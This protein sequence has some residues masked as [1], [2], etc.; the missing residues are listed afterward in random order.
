MNAKH[1]VV[2][3]GS[4][5]ENSGSKAV[6]EINGLVLR[7]VVSGEAGEGLPYAP[8]NWPNPGDI[9]KWKAGKRKSA[10]GLM[11][12]RYIYLPPSLQKTAEGRKGFASKLSL[13]EFIK[14]EYPTV[15]LDAF[16]ATF[17]WKMPSTDYDPDAS[18]SGLRKPYGSKIK[19]ET[20]KC[21]IGN[22]KCSLQQSTKKRSLPTIDC[23]ICCSESG[24]CRECCC[25]L[26]CKTIDSGYQGYNFIRCQAKGSENLNYVCGHIAHIECALRTYMAGTI[27]GSIELDAEYYCRRCDKRTDLI[28]Y[29]E[30]ILQTCESHNSKDDI[31]KILNMIFCI[32]RGSRKEKAK[33]LLK[34]SNLVLAKLN[35]GNCLDEIWNVEDNNISGV[36][37]DLIESQEDEYRIAMD[38]L[39]AQ[40]KVLLDLY[41]QLETDRSEL[42]KRTSSEIDQ[43]VDNLIHDFSSKVNQIKIEVG[44]LKEMEKVAKGFGMVPKDTLKAHFGLQ[45]EN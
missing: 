34:R 1:L 43:G 7:P 41:Q 10:N 2:G 24:F 16:F 40:K 21:R 14:K 8:V 9:W 38:N 28:P 19:S 27:G 45:I 4:P 6:L 26:C 17:S 44:K 18:G 42:A 23:D 3:S 5:S 30:L 32:L 31:D 37:A 39:N 22:K 13:L 11:Q 25:I 36:S 12:D 29:V 35:G 33:K 20:M 15:D